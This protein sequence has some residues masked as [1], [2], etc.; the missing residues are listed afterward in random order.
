MSRD[1]RQNKLQL[2]QKKQPRVT[3]KPVQLNIIQ[4]S[5]QLSATQELQVNEPECIVITWI[6]RQ[7][8]KLWPKWNKDLSNWDEAIIE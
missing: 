1:C 2:E 7:L 4:E 3:Q 5:A 8:R 6:T